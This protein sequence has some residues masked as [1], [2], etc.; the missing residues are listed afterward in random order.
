MEQR[1]KIAIQKKGRLFDSSINLL[2]KSG[3]NF[4]SIKDKLI[5]KC[6][7]AP[8]DILL[9]RNNDIADLLMD[10]V[11]DLGI[12]GLNELRECELRRRKEKKPNKFKLLRKLNFGHCRLS[13]AIPKDKNFKDTTILNNSRIATSYPFILE[14]FALKNNI[15]INTTHLNGSVELAPKAKLSDYIC[16]LVSTGMTLEQ[17]DLR[18]VVEIFSSTAA[19]VQSNTSNQ[20][21]ELLIE[22]LIPRVNG[23]IKASYTKYIMLHAPKNNLNEIINLLPGK[24]YPTLLPHGSDKNKIIIHSV[25][26]EQVFW[27]TMENLRELGANSILV[28]PI[29]KILE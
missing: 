17:N 1:L 25:C 22:M 10:G 27:E 5:L 15:K 19:L 3:L 18:E 29:E 11:I 2:K 16:D 7:N 8:I 4:G 6:E 20:Q 28:V 23:I 13:I 14:D 21:H 9:L 26:N 12:I 24:D